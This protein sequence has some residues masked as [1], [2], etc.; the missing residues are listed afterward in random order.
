[1]LLRYLSDIKK[2]YKE[3]ACIKGNNPT[4]FVDNVILF[5]KKYLPVEVKL[6]V[7]AT[8]NIN[9]Q[10]CK[11]CDDD[12]IIIDKKANRRIAKEKIYSNRVLV[13]DTEAIYIY[14]FENDILMKIYDLDNLND[15][16]NLKEIKETI[17]R[18]L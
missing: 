4:S 7:R 18:V 12:Q 16:E 11:Y 13:I 15:E 14:K 10:L 5:C 17:Y 8:L 3:C 2:I 6:L 1:M 9:H